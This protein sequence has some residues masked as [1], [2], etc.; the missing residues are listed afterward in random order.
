MKAPSLA[1]PR[2]DVPFRLYTDASDNG[3]GAVFSQMLG[4]E[5]VIAY[6]SRYG[7]VVDIKFSVASLL[8][9]TCST[10]QSFLYINTSMFNVTFMGY[11]G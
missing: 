6:A 11:F 3:I 2:F 1:F 7:I 9:Y 8:I 10:D 4:A 5:Q